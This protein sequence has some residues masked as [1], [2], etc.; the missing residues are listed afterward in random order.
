MKL[1]VALLT[2]LLIV[3]TA[4]AE[5]LVSGMSAEE[6]MAAFRTA[7]NLEFTAD[8]WSEPAIPEWERAARETCVA[9]ISTVTVV[10]EARESDANDSL[11]YVR[12]A[13]WEADLEQAWLGAA[14]YALLTV[15]PANVAVEDEFVLWL[16]RER[17][18]QN[19]ELRQFGNAA[20]SY[21]DYRGTPAVE[22]RH[23]ADD[24]EYF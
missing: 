3:S 6:F 15:D 12:V 20:V 9:H 11:D 17:A 16:G 21:R 19:E 18:M 5:P 14:L 1:L 24:H 10:A 7:S 22:F 13:Y 2:G 4:K 8:C 23:P